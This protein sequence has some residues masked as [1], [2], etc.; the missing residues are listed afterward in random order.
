MTLRE[1]F[2]YLWSDKIG[3]A[4]IVGV[5]LVLLLLIAFGIYL[6]HEER[7]WE[8]FKADHNCTLVGKVDG[9]SM[10]GYGIS[11]NGTISFSVLHSAEQEGWACDDGVTYWR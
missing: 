10:P 2:G 6:M 7:E 8:K 5:V 3:R 4:A 9:K 1:D 11:S